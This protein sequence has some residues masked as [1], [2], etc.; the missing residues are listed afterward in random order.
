MCRCLEQSMVLYGSLFTGTSGVPFVFFAMAVTNEHWRTNYSICLHDYRHFQSWARDNTDATTW[1][2]FRP[3]NYW[4]L[5]YISVATPFKH[6]DLNIF[7]SI[8]ILT[9]SVFCTLSR[10]NCRKAKNCRV[11]SAGH[12]IR[13]YCA[14]SPEVF[15]VC[16]KQG[17]RVV[18]NYPR[19]TLIRSEH[20]YTC[21]P[22]AFLQFRLLSKPEPVLFQPNF[23]HI[24]HF[25][26]LKARFF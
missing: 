14:A 24:L 6:R 9:K 7:S 12:F 3:R 18:H 25:F 4:L 23:P 8:V 11:P 17:E 16:W 15:R 26:M 10:S 22:Q 2:F 20:S 21:S 5:H 13:Y 19:V 1:P